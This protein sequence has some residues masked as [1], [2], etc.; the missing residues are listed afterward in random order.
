MVM[1]EGDKYFIRNFQ[2]VG[3]KLFRTPDLIETQVFR[4]APGDVFSTEKLQK[5]ID[6]L[7]KLYGRFWVYR[8]CSFT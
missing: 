8:F 7:R 2:F 4:M 6:A 3:M 1:Q 5:G